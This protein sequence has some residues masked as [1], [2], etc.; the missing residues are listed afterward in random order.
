MV[1]D[2][3]S[4]DS[5]ICKKYIYEEDVENIKNDNS[6]TNDKI[7]DEENIVDMK[8]ETNENISN[9]NYNEE[10]PSTIIEK[11]HDVITNN[12]LEE[13]HDQSNT[14]II[15]PIVKECND[16]NKDICFTRNETSIHNISENSFQH[17]KD[18]ISNFN[19]DEVES[20]AQDE[21]NEAKSDDSK[22]KIKIQNLLKLIGLLKA[23]INQKDQEIYKMEVDFKLRNEENEKKIFKLEEIIEE[24]E[25]NTERTEGDNFMMSKMKSILISQNEEIASLNEE[26]KKKSK[27]IFYLNEENMTKDEKLVEL[28][29]EIES[30]YMHLREYKNFQNELEVDV[31]N[32]IYSAENYVNR[33]NQRLIENNIDIKEKK[34]NIEKQ[35][36]IIKELYNELNKKEEKIS[37]LRSIIESIEL[38]N[39]RDIIKYKQN[40][41]DLINR[42][43]LNNSLMNSQKIEIENMH[44]N[45]KQLEEELKNKD[46]ELKKLHQNLLSKDEENNKMVHDINRLK[47]DMEVRNI[48][49]DNVKK[50]IKNVKKEYAINLKKQKERY[51][52]VINEIYKEKDEI[53][54][55]HVDELAKLSNHYNEVVLVNENIKNEMNFLNDEILKKSCEIEKLQDRL[56]DYESKLLIY[57]NN[58]EIKILKKNEDHLR[59][60]L[61]KHIHRNEQ[62]LNTTFLLQKSTLENNSLEKKIIELRAKSYRKDQEIK[63][64]QETKS[65]RKS[66]SS[67]CSHNSH[68]YS[69][70]LSDDMN[71][72]NYNLKYYHNNSIGDHENS[73]YT[74]KKS[75]DKNNTIGS[76]ADSDKR[77]IKIKNTIPQSN[78]NEDPVHLALCEYINCFKKNNLSININKLDDNTYLLNDKKV[79]ISFING[80]LYVEDDACP[81]KLQDYLLK[82]TVR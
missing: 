79:V 13:K 28:K 32:K 38:N 72:D 5:N 76:L 34:L 55:N 24:N 48:D 63:K 78:N 69:I 53:I 58:N 82:T 75:Y 64:L 74:S 41:M 4:E 66:P 51:T 67:N 33:T 17:V 3:K 14:N 46:N 56:L 10:C 11:G 2:T 19:L 36:R 62:L 23:Q 45:Y 59:K 49:I 68:E 70:D 71:E 1:T 15:V 26:L 7:N 8:K 18:H 43:S 57:E 80:D 25:S 54:K 44:M 30:N 12:V 52:N 81:I 65:I 29:K 42:L 40:N 39:S 27:E 47:F 60:L 35:K 6:I 50:K 61:S 20:S 31:N 21:T 22:M 9:L 37:E 73:V 77:S 16:S